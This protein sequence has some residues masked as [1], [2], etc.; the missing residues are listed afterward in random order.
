MSLDQVHSPSGAA[1]VPLV[2]S[3]IPADYDRLR[4]L[5]EIQNE[6]ARSTGVAQA[7]A[8]TL[9]I[10]AQA[11]EV[12]T[13][14][15]L[16]ATR[17]DDRA[18]AW[19]A[20]GLPP[21]A[22]EYAEAHARTVLSYLTSSPAP[23][24]SI[25][26]EA[27]AGHFVTLPLS[28]ATGHAFGVFQLE[29]A[30]P[31][32]ERDLLFIDAVVNQL[33]TAF[34]RHRTD[35]SRAGSES[36]HRRLVEI[37]AISSAALDG[38]TL[39]ESLAAILEAIGV[40]FTTTIAAIALA[41]PDGKTL[42]RWRSSGL[43]R[44]SA[45]G[46]SFGV[47]AARLLAATETAI[48]FDAPGELDALGP[49]LSANE[50]SSFMGVRLRVRDRTIGAVYV[51]SSAAGRFAREDAALLKAVA[52]RIA[53]I[54]EHAALHDI[55]LAAV[56]SREAVLGR[57]SHDLR[58]PL[59]T[60]QLWTELLVIDEPR[61]AKGMGAI[62]RA[63]TRMN[64]M[65]DDLLDLDSIEAGRLAVVLSPEHAEALV[66]EALDGV[67]G[68][69]LHK[70]L[71]IHT[72]LQ[73]AHPVHC[74][75]GRIVQVLTNLVANAIKFTP[76]GGT[77]TVELFTNAEFAT[78]SVAD[79]GCGIAVSDLPHV[80]EPHW[81]AKATA[82]EGRG[83][84]LAIAKGII[85]GHGGALSVASQVGR[86]TTFSFT[87]PLARSSVERSNG[88]VTSYSDLATGV[89]EPRVLVIDDEVNALSALGE[90][91]AEDGFIVTTAT[92]G[93]SA[94]ASVRTAA[95]DILVAD[96]ELPGISGTQLLREL[97]TI[98]P[99]IPVI[100]MTG[101]EDH[102]IAAELR[103]LDAGYI[104]KP[105]QIKELTSKIRR[106]LARTPAP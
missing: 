86:G 69:A 24:G 27:R 80:F 92:D 81:Q 91:L 40:M 16:D 57:V 15:L 58:N 66:E 52:D 36:A 39:D 42:L 41:S 2:R 18:F 106:A 6:L 71:K 1:H 79:T 48:V 64:R 98:L 83:L 34:Q 21:R 72:R 32:Q 76:E 49:M 5:Y 3:P 105:I 60:I 84:G 13:A 75:R 29:G 23:R 30:A 77:I 20:D 65:I 4:G 85:E 19:A 78:F 9:S 74:D 68:A 12:R 47:D 10:V 17:A 95:P 14:V 94:L 88:P 31:F 100:L 44:R 55:A 104:G 73:A 7:C 37:Q 54:V 63:V 35:A 45:D 96:L 93:P 25:A 102:R 51:G 56:G 89:Q 97:R 50:V 43:E 22:L 70:S 38:T 62:R 33:A 46:A 11:L 28:L 26:G 82:P 53:V 90:L 61:L 99:G 8:T 59:N 103:E 67:R 101:Y 87:L